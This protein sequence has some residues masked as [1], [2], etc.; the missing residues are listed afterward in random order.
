LELVFSKIEIGFLL[1]WLLTVRL[2]PIISPRAL[3]ASFEV[4]NCKS[5]IAK[6]SLFDGLGHIESFFSRLNEVLFR[7]TYGGERL[8]PDVLEVIG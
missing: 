3:W 1:V 8:V 6:K 7:C 4:K 2:P 5:R